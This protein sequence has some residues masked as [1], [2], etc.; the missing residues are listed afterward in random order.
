MYYES[1]HCIIIYLYV[2]DRHMWVDG[3]MVSETYTRWADTEP[4]GGSTNA[5]GYHNSHYLSDSLK[6]DAYHA[7]CEMSEYW[8]RL[9]TLTIYYYILLRSEMFGLLSLAFRYF[10]ADHGSE[11]CILRKIKFIWWDILICISI[12]YIERWKIENSQMI[13]FRIQRYIIFENET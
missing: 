12:Y 13:V 6:S 5:V 9:A 4:N 11:K 3:K 2:S 7:T 8:M 10:T 1:I